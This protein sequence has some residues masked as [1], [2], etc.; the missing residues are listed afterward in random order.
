MA[1]RVTQPSEASKCNWA[2][3]G[4]AYPNADPGSGVRDVGFKPKDYPTAGPGGVIPA[5]DHNFLW[6]LGM[7]ML[8]WVRDFIAREYADVAEGIASTTNVSQL[9][10]VYPPIAGMYDRGAELFNV[11]G[12]ATGGGAIQSPITDGEQIYYWSGSPPQILVAA[13]PIDGSEIWESSAVTTAFRSIAADGAFVYATMTGAGEPGLRRWNRSTGAFSSSGGTEYNCPE[14]VTNGEFAVGVGGS[15]GAGNVTVWSG[16]QGTI[17]QDGAYNTGSSALYA[18]AID[19]EYAFAGGVRNT[20]DVWAVRLSDRV[21]VWSTAF[22]TTTA[23]TVY[24]I[25][26][27][28][29][30]V[31]VVTD[32]VTLTAG[33]SAN[34]FVLSRVNGAVQW[35]GNLAG[36]ADLINGVAVDDRYLYICDDATTT[37]CWVYRLRAPVIMLVAKV[38]DLNHP[39]VDGVSVI[40]QTDSDTTKFRRH[41]MLGATKT[42]MRAKSDDPARRPFHTLAVPTDGRI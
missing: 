41:W 42:F 34:L 23:P 32:Q 5:E 25:A 35:T 12:T 14:L 9:F 38:V 36:G 40:G 16:I 18:A 22:A 13:D 39:S 15:L 10:R 37:V 7:E 20:N 33:G 1:E 6:R 27:D 2:S 4:G 21:N 8:S 28:G 30:H 26:T 3:G 31:F 11:S 19:H 24:G 29:D 17:T